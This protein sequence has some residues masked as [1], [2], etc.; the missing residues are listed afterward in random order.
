M[1]AAPD[2][3]AAAPD[4]QA[5]YA[6]TM[7]SAKQQPCVESYCFMCATPASHNAGSPRRTSSL[8][9]HVG[10]SEA[11]ACCCGCRGCGRARA[12][13]AGAASRS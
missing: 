1:Q 6:A 12:T 9:S 5:A 8:C 7:E 3:Q 4:T 10:E 2:A 13:A 11:A